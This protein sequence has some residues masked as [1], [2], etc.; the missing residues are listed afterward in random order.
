MASQ[1]K[2]HLLNQEDDIKESEDEMTTK[3]Q[4]QVTINYFCGRRQIHRKDFY[5]IMTTF[6]IVSLILVALFITAAVR[7]HKFTHLSPSKPPQSTHVPVA[8]FPYKNFRLPAYIRPSYYSIDLRPKYNQLL[9]DGSVSI[10]ITTSKKTNFII[11][12]K[13]FIT[14]HHVT[15][16]EAN[17]KSIKVVKTAEYPKYNFYYMKLENSLQPNQKYVIHLTFESRI[18][19]KVLHG[20]YRSHYQTP[21]GITR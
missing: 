4:D 21:R 6:T 19:T 3:K 18:K 2:Y 5:L 12:H 11:L 16:K 10:N 7:H 14:I 1:N 9:T 8:P 13:K 17:G 20:F 15:V